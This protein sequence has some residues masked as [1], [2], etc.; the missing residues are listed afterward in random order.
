MPERR[1]QRKPYLKP[2]ALAHE[3]H[4]ASVKAA[5]GAVAAMSEA[6]ATLTPD[7]RKARYG[8]AYVRSVCAQAGVSLQEMSP[9][10][11]VLA[12]DCDITFRAGARVSAQVKCTSAFKIRGHSI[13]WPV[14]TEWVKKWQEHWVPV[15]LVIVIV[16]VDAAE[17]IKHN[18]V[19][20]TFH[21]TA[22]FWRQVLPDE[23]IGRRISIPKS[24]R[25]QS[26]TL[27]LWHSDF[28]ETF[29]PAG[30]KP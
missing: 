20:G 12:V 24:Q 8:V 22:A 28:L 4:D 18:P 29:N 27:A 6:W 21:Q 17:W 26:S 5:T 19:E 14:K 23:H 9:D 11:D 30:G 13:S 16:P 1:Q 25:F 7:G 3:T 2:A 15:Y 10:E